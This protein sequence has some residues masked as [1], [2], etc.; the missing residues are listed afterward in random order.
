MVYLGEAE[1]F[2]RHVA[3]ARNG[4]VGR[5]GSRAYLLKQLADGVSVQERSQSAFSH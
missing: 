5:K 2:E 4:G 1:V 3:Q